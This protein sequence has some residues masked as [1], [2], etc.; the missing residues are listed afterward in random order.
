MPKTRGVNFMRPLILDH[1]CALSWRAQADSTLK[2]EQDAT[3]A[4]K[5]GN[6]DVT[7]MVVGLGANRCT[8]GINEEN[9]RT[10][11]GRTAHAAN[12]HVQPPAPNWAS[13]CAFGPQFGVTSFV[14]KPESAES[15]LRLGLRT[16]M[17]FAPPRCRILAANASFG[18][19]TPTT[20]VEVERDDESQQQVPTREE[21]VHGRVL[22]R[23]DPSLRRAR[24]GAR[25]SAFEQAFE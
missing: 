20:D 3:A 25:F 23:Y 9:R 15:T 10:E 13:P 4:C 12:Q 1:A 19:D 24:L 18:S 16:P 21:E 7:G 5:Q 22:L 6:S 8:D 14:L 2:A 17:N 11:A